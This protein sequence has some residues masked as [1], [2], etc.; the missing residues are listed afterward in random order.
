MFLI[1]NIKGSEA[2]YLCISEIYNDGTCLC[3]NICS[4]TVILTE[5]KSSE[6]PVKQKTN[7]AKWSLPTFGVSTM[8]RVWAA[9]VWPAP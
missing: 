6:L 7:H 4:G 3:E 1:R 8:A 5:K 9:I 2:C